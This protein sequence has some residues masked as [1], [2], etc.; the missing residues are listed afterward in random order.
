M[1]EEEPGVTR[2]LDGLR[3]LALEQFGAGPYG[4]MFLADLGAEVIK[5]ENA[6]TAGEA[7]RHVGPHML[8]DNDSQYFQSFNFNKKSVVLNVKSPQGRAALLR[9]VESSNALLNNLRGDQPEKLGIDYA[10]LKA[11]NPAIVCL[12]ISAYGRDNARAAWPGYDYLMQAEAGLMSITGEPDGPPSRLGPS[13]IDYMT[14]V[15]GMVGLL[16]GVIRARQTGEGCDVDTSLFDVALHQLSY[17]AV[18]YLNGGDAPSRLPRSAHPSLVPVQTYRTADGWIFVMCM[19]DSFW[20]ALADAVGR[21][22]LK[23]DPRFASQAARRRNRDLL[24]T[25]LDDAF[26]A[27]LTAEW[28]ARLTGTVPVAPVHDVAQAFA[29]PFVQELG[30]V[31]TVPHPAKPDF[32][33]LASP[34]KVNGKRP[35]Q[36]ACSA[37]GADN[38]TYVGSPPAI[39]I[40]PRPGPCL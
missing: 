6:A 15:V 29:S 20:E 7:S 13:M 23:S 36:A 1:G 33:A 38:E 2:L 34:L 8:G 11:T 4:S 12:H 19:K 39:P 25:V 24:T 5:V 35:E 27:R 9:L 28:L 18:W 30:M 40:H 14:G 26:S 37:L 3:I 32:K 31:R 21:P 10:S 17:P 16:S 22:E